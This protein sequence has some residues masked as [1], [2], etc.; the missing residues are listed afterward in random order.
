M[1]FI[2]NGAH[3]GDEVVEDEFESLKE[4]YQRLGEIVCCDRDV[5]LRT[6]AKENVV[7][8]T[9]LEQE[10]VKRFG[11]IDD[12]TVEARFEALKEEHGGDQN[13]YDNT[14]FNRGDRNVILAKLKSSLTV[15]RLLE[16][17]VSVPDKATEEELERYYQDNLQ[18][19]LGEEEVRVSQIFIEPSSHEAAREAYMALRTVRRELLAGKDFDQAAR[20]HGSD[21]DREI[22]LGWMKQGQTMPEVEA[23]TFSMEVGEI[24]P[25]VATHYGFHLF[26][27]TDRKDAKP[28]PRDQISGFEEK[29]LSERRAMGIADLIDRIKSTSTVEEVGDSFS[30]SAH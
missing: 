6:Y 5:E 15:D 17:E 26:K 8:R 13:F 28:I 14:G 20:E 4:H 12:A 27:V 29:Y 2:I 30:R 9:L 7:N 22:D 24:S 19:F 23:I 3:V 18:R 16:A 1:A 25:I 10:S 11:E 21:E